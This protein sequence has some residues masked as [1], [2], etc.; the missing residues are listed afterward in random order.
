MILGFLLLLTGDD[1]GLGPLIAGFRQD[2]RHQGREKVD[3]GEGEDEEEEAHR[4]KS[5]NKAPSVEK[6][7]FPAGEEAKGDFDFLE[8]GVDGDVKAVPEKVSKTFLDE[9]DRKVGEGIGDP[10]GSQGDGD[11]RSKKDRPNPGKK[12]LSGHGQLGDKQSDGDASGN[13][14]PARVP[15]F[16]L[17]HRFDALLKP[18]LALH[19]GAPQEAVDLPNDAEIASF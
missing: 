2:F 13:R 16:P 1:F 17:E 4:E 8:N 9:H 11:I 18:C 19:S 10:A 12:H 6:F 15:K 7:S 14:V 5:Q 3:G